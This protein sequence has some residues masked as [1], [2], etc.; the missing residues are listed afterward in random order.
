MRIRA[1]EE[2]VERRK[3][4]LAQLRVVKSKELSSVGDERPDASAVAAALREYENALR[5]EENMRTLFPGVKIVAP[6][7]PAAASAE[8]VIAAKQFLGIDLEPAR[9]DDKE[10]TKGLS[11]GSIAL[12][13]VVALS[14]LALLYMLSFDPMASY[15]ILGGNTPPSSW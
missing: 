3:A 8:D 5:G 4:A 15:G 13:A 10:E 11:A 2:A 7:G 14:Q 12:L 9:N 6:N 1:V